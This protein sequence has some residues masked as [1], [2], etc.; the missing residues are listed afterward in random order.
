MARNL[1]ELVG[2]TKTSYTAEEFAESIMDHLMESK[3]YGPPRLTLVDGYKNFRV[4]LV[5]Q[6]ETIKRLDEAA[7][8]WQHGPSVDDEDVHKETGEKM[9]IIRAACSGNRFHRLIEDIAKP[10]Y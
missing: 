6:E 4:R 5:N 7:I 9:V 3:K 2:G 1:L 8:A 10:V